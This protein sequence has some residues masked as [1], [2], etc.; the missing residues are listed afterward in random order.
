[1]GHGNISNS[2]KLILD[3]TNKFINTLNNMSST[4]FA[5]LV[6]GGVLWK[7]SQQITNT[8]GFI[9]NKL[10]DITKAINAAVIAENADSSAKEKNAIATQQNANAKLAEARATEEATAAELANTRGKD[11]NTAANK[12]NTLSSVLST[13]K[14]KAKGFA[15]GLGAVVGKLGGVANAAG[16]AMMAVGILSEVF[17]R[18]ANDSE[19]MAD[20]LKSQAEDLQAQEEILAR[21]EKALQQVPLLTTALRRLQEQ[22][23]NVNADSEEGKKLQDEY[24]NTR[25]F[26]Q[27]II[28]NENT[29]V[30][31]NKQFT[32]DA[33]NEIMSAEKERYAQK[34]KDIKDAQD[35]LR[36]A[37]QEQ[38]N[39]T[40]K[41]ITA[42]DVQQNSW[43]DLCESVA[44]YGNI[45]QRVR[46]A[47]NEMMRD[48]HTGLKS[49]HEDTLA[50]YEE[51]K[52]SGASY[53]MTAEG[54]MS[55]DT[56]I[57]NEKQ[58]IE[59]EDRKS[60]V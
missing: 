34:K 30:L 50:S 2:L 22:Q 39:D 6:G 47:F 42:L 48:A 12:R 36:K 1:M 23:E 57:F 21:Q 8:L 55:I 25:S 15:S 35:L 7:F 37:F 13:G 3:L 56:A 28:G 29:A 18:A 41:A 43:A 24:N 4:S 20:S 59:R 17:V 32:V 51:M 54:M 46:M 9:H 10:L 26:L 38:L 44:Q 16:L 45:L 52:K 19:K 40:I 49:M 27:S 11:A 33:T 14:D 58:A 60:V 31:E 5:L 53:V